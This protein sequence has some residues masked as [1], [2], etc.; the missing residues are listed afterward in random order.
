VVDLG[1]PGITL[2]SL[3]G[4]TYFNMNAQ[5]LPGATGLAAY[6]FPFKTAWLGGSLLDVMGSQASNPN[7]YKVD[8]VRQA[9]DGFLVIPN[10]DGSIYSTL[11]LFGSN[12]VVNGQTYANGFEALR[13]LAN[14]N[15]NSANLQDQYFG[16]WDGDLYFKTVQVWVD[17]N[18]SGS[19]DPG[20]LMSLKDA[21]VVAINTCYVLNKQEEDAFGNGTSMRSAFLYQSGEDIT[22]NQAEILNR[23]NTGYTSSGLPAEFRL[24]VDVLFQADPTQ[25]LDPGT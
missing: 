7:G 19:V 2:S 20:E 13:A 6:N 9:D 21:G 15:C 5:T 18:R 3:F 10:S 25:T 8:V 12:M 23:L 4:G 24:I 1:E 11:N 16:P 14:K 22:G 17:K